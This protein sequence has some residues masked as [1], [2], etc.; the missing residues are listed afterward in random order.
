MVPLSKT[1]MRSSLQGRMKMLKLVKIK[2]VTGIF[3]KNKILKV[4]VFFNEYIFA[5]KRI[6]INIV[7][8]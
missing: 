3:F 6:Y 1:D 5:S 8:S 2:Y 4:A 7:P